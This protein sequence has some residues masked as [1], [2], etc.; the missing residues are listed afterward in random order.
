MVLV[1]SSVDSKVATL[2]IALH[3]RK[4]ARGYHHGKAVIPLMAHVVVQRGTPVTL[5]MGSAVE[6]K[7]NV[8]R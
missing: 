2:A 7:A 5:C 8:A 6:V 1:N 4:I 3:R